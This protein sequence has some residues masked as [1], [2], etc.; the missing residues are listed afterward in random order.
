LKKESHTFVDKE[1]F[2]AFLQQH[3]A[4]LLKSDTAIQIRAA[5]TH[6]DMVAPVLDLLGG[7]YPHLP[8]LLQPAS[9]AQPVE[10]ELYTGIESANKKQP[11]IQ[12]M[13]QKIFQSYS[14]KAMETV[15]SML[16]QHQQKEFL[17]YERMKHEQFKQMLHMIAH[18]WRQPLNTIN[19]LIMKMMVESPTGDDQN[20]HIGS[21]LHAIEQQ[22]KKLSS[23][24]DDFLQPISC[25]S[26]SKEYFSVH[27]SIS[28][29]HG[30]LL[31]SFSYDGVIFQNQIDASLQIY[32]NKHQF[33]QVM[34]YLYSNAKEAF[35]KENKT[36][37]KITLTAEKSDNGV[38]LY[39]KNNAPN[40]PK[41]IEPHIFNPYFTTELD[42]G[43]TG[44]GLYFVKEM[45]RSCFG[46]D[47]TYSRLKEGSCFI[48]TFGL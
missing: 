12:S 17:L 18:Q 37:K 29:L 27:E 28:D 44:L 16:Q 7:K 30:L 33:L 10:I 39:F 32:G 15:S 45:M 36:Q 23:V 4:S 48:L 20:E 22:T 2:S 41:E 1:A 3:E 35:E 6:K 42:R 38:T 43:K 40:I 21:D 11:G 5:D 24:I 46:G 13:Q 47:I 34:Q 9:P 19:A 26:E 14:P 31:P 8:I 25:Q